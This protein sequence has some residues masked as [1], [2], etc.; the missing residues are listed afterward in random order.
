MINKISVTK[1]EAAKIA[2]TSITTIDDWLAHGLPAFRVGRKVLIS[3]NLLTKWIDDKSINR[4]G[5]YKPVSN[6]IFD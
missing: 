5:F 4:E 2:S 6:T 3:V 1:E